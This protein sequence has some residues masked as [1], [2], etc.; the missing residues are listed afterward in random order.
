[1]DNN[2]FFEHIKCNICG[3]DKTTVV[4]PSSRTSDEVVSIETFRSSGEEQLK[5]PLVKCEGCGFQYVNP[6]LNSQ[7]VMEGYTQAVD[8]RFVTQSEGRELTFKKCLNAIQ[9]VWAKEPGKILDI[10]TANGSFLKVAKDAGWQV[11]GCEP[12]VWMGK[13]CKENYGIDIIQ[14]DVFAG[15]YEDESFDVITL[16]DVLEHTPDP[17][18]VLGEC[19][20]ILKP[21]GLLV[22]NYPDIDS[23]IAKMMKKKWVFLLSV[24]YYY[25]TPATIRRALERVGLKPLLMKPHFQSL[26]LNY[27]ISR[28]LP[29]LGGLGSK[30]E[31]LAESKA[32]SRLQV[33]YWMG[34]TLVIAR[35]EKGK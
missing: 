33:P 32:L 5:E 34:Q 7:Y 35:K 17:M 15:K 4:Y 26:A 8:E 25:F 27:I 22:I 9:K 29:Y 11:S 31:G 12:N 1:M 18:K 10:G 2:N 14:G 20:R 23:W 19:V 16:W 3:E 30:L 21:Q 13:W 24:H 28:A 6:R